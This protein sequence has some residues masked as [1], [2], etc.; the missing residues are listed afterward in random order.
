MVTHLPDVISPPK[1]GPLETVDEIPTEKEYYKG[2][3]KLNIQKI[4]CRIYANPTDCLHQSSCGWCGNYSAC[5][6][7][8]GFGPL[9]PCNKSTFIYSSTGMGVG[10]G[11][12]QNTR[13]I[14]E[15]VGNV[16]LTV[17]TN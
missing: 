4:N 10:I 11:W 1:K 16:S 6:M 5:I 8:N 3:N 13:R 2:E 17:A 7:G 9:Q 12:E 14:N 15:Q